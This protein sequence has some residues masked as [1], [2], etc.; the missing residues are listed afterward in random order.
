MAA[1]P[2]AH[3]PA[4]RPTRVMDAAHEFD[5]GLHA[6]YGKVGGGLS[7]ITLA[8]AWQ[9]WALHL[10]TQPAKALGLAAQAQTAAVEWLATSVGAG[11]HNPDASTH[12]VNNEPLRDPRFAAPE[13]QQWP[14]AGW[15]QAHHQAERW[16]DTATQLEGMNRHHTDVVHAFARQWL[17]MLS[18]SNSPANPEI[19]KVTREEAGANLLRGAENALDDWREEHGLARLK[20]RERSYLPGRDVAVTPGAVVFRNRLVEL[21]QYAPTTKK[22]QAEPIF[23]VPSWIMKYYILDLS[24]HNSFVRW[25]TDQGHTVFILSWHNPDEA[26]A[27]IEFNDYLDWGIFEPLKAI[28]RI[29]PD[30]P[31]HACG[32]CLGGTL[33]A[34]ACAALAR[35][36]QVRGAD[37]M[38]ALASVTLLAAE[39]DFKEPGELGIF[40]DESQVHLLEAMMRERGY[41]TGKQ[42]AGSF[43]FLHARDLVWSARMRAYL[44]G[45]RTDPNDLMAWNADTTRMPA[46]MHSQYL[47]RLYLENQLAEHRYEVEDRPVALSD[48]RV[49]MFVVGTEKDHVSPWHSVYKIHSLT[50]TEVTFALANGGHNAG[51]VSEPGHARRHYRILTT[52]ASS[53]WMAPDAWE[54]AA[55]RHEGSWW[56]AWNDWLKAR[57][58]GTVQPRTIPSEAVLD[59]APG[60]YVHEC[61][62][63]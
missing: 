23:I 36:Q 46:R 56:E 45:E 6:L 39:T 3:L 47:H 33:L 8:L 54:Q 28:R 63:D 60:R 55:V 5:R 41:L 21:I 50:E 22:V 7:P 52:P 18:P 42:M 32:Y 31:V 1:A 43:Q 30:A 11:A 16:W 27:A 14:W 25:L 13:W 51:I 35:P 12:I 37:E 24:P 62:N 17:D 4:A 20:P 53:P 26:D 57:S 49:P 34:I 61:Y 58:R 2:R 15:V 59:A 19:M 40:I 10:V 48:L 38:P 29:V 9:D 44:F